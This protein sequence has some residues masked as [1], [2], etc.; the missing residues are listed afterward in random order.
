MLP[1]SSPPLLLLSSS[2]PSLLLSSSSP[3]PLL[4]SLHTQNQSKSL[5]ALPYVLSLNCQVESEKDREF[6]RHQQAAS[7]SWLPLSMELTLDEGNKL[8]VK[9][10]APEENSDYSTPSSQPKVHVCMM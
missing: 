4:P 10:L 5:R 6:W 1:F 8:I 2:P 3:P 7:S 9:E